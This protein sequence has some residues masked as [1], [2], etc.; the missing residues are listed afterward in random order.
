MEAQ[1]LRENENQVQ[2]LPKRILTD[3]G[4]SPFWSEN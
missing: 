4:Y 3:A 1:R 2:F